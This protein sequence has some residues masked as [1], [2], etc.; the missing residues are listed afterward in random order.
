[1]RR[2]RVS[3]HPAIVECVQRWWDGART[4][5]ESRDPA[6]TLPRLFLRCFGGTSLVVEDITGIRAFL[7]GLHSADNPAEAYIHLVAVDP[8]LRGQGLARGMYAAFMTRAAAAGRHEVRALT[9]PGNA[10]A[11][12]FH[13][14]MGFSP[15]KGDRE[16]EGL[17]V[18]SD[19]N[20]PGQ[21]R[22]CFLK[23]LPV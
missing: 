23:K 2:A 12:A 20:G 5:A 14:A 11:L 21:D 7:I 19:H 9:S 15:E 16:I 22:V 10:G 1:M 6:L 18:H 17:P 4:P 13:R 3:D 8:E